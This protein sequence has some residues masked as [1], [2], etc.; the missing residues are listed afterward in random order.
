MPGDKCIL[1]KMNGE[2][3]TWSI[4]GHESL[5]EICSVLHDCPF[6][7]DRA[8]FDRDRETWNGVF[9]APTVDPAIAKRP[10]NPEGLEIQRKSVIHTVYRFPLFQMV[11]SLHGV[12]AQQVRD[13]SRIGRYT[14]NY[15]RKTA[16]GW[17]LVFCE[18]MEID[19]ALAGIPRGELR[20]EG[21]CGR[22][23]VT[24]LFGI[25]YSG[26]NIDELKV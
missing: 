8:T 7:L 21:E 10:V 25:I 17:R 26:I 15:C 18:D 5:R 11:L 12:S 14:F 9:F 22:G 4:D 24:R 20:N 16:K 6:E 19:L 23:H 3:R 13:G 2:V 1:S